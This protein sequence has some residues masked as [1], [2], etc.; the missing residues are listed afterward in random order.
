MSPNHT[1]SSVVV[2]QLEEEDRRELGYVPIVISCYVTP[3]ASFICLVLP[4]TP[5]PSSSPPSSPYLAQ[6]IFRPTP[7]TVVTP[8]L[9]ASVL[10]LDIAPVSY[11]L[12][13]TGL[14]CYGRGGHMY[15]TPL[16]PPPS[17]LCPELGITTAPR[18]TTSSAFSPDIVSPCG[19]IF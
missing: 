18:C 10:L 2:V 15:P 17:L 3:S 7:T 19:G 9:P 5:P 13:Y 6:G 14:W 12:Q 8:V 1:H 16:D 4:L 11:E